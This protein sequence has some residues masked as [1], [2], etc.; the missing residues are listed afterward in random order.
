MSTEYPPFTLGKSRYDQV[1]GLTKMNLGENN[2]IPRP[3]AG[4]VHKWFVP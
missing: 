4:H 1:S 2:E 3:N